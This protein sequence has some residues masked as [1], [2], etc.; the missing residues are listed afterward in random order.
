ML[1]E[2]FFNPVPPQ[3]GRDF[4]FYTCTFAQLLRNENCTCT[5]ELPR[6]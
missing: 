3:E 4:V 5:V 1:L 6:R 2:G